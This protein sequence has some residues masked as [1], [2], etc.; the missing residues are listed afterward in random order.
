MSTHWPTSGLILSMHGLITHQL[1]FTCLWCIGRSFGLFCHSKISINQGDL[2]R[3]ADCDGS[4]NHG[5]P[6][7][8]FQG[9]FHTFSILFKTPQCPSVSED[10]LASYDPY[11]KL[12]LHSLLTSYGGGH[13]SHLIQGYFLHMWFES[14]SFQP[15]PSISIYLLRIKTCYSI[16]TR[17]NWM[18]ATTT[19]MVM[20]SNNNNYHPSL[21]LLSLAL[22]Y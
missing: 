12:C 5:T 11:H 19:N 3:L 17:K 21:T 22:V 8:F 14:H 9:L 15:F 7:W 4:H 20:T 6:W 16:P 10:D 2:D 13:V 1:N 18:T